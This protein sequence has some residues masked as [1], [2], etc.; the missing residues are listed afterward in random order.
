ML[1]HSL[2]GEIAFA[3]TDAIVYFAAL[4]LLYGSYFSL[5]TTFAGATPGMQFCNLAVV[6]LDGSLPDTR[7][8]LWR[9]FGYLLS[10]VTMMMGFLWTLW[11]ED[12][13]SWQDRISQT[14]I[15]AAI[16]LDAGS[17]GIDTRQHTFAQN[18]K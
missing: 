4:Y 12:H 16:P 9:S 1:F 10:G 3:K 18:N 6:R 13:F 15:T 14:Y 8:L 7:Q 11:D 5:F 2:G 17:S